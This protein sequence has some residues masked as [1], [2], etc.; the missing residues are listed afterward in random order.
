MV[1]PTTED[2]STIKE[3]K[4][5]IDATMWI[6]LKCIGLSEEKK[7]ASLKGFIQYNSISITFPKCQNY[8]HGG[9]IAGFQKLEMVVRGQAS[10]EGRSWGITIKQ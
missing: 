7:K 6:N 10:G 4:L 8:R 1:H 3:N 5:L 9:Q 2:N